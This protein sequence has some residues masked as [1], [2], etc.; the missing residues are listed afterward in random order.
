[1]KRKLITTIVAF[2]AASAL[3]LAAC[4]SGSAPSA[5]GTQGEATAA[6]G[7]TSGAAAAAPDAGASAGMQE[8]GDFVYGIA[9]EID[10]FDPFTATTADAKSVYFNIYEGLVKVSP[11]GTFKGAVA[12]DYKISDDAKTYTFTLRRE[13]PQRTGSYRRRCHLLAA[14]RERQQDDR[15]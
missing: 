8:G 2:A 11:D 3:A 10:N 9:T 12:S 5:S 4:G 7:S 6:E 13:I 15:V 14:A 1:M